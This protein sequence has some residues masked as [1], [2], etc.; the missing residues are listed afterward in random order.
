MTDIN[1]QKKVEEGEKHVLDLH[2][3]LIDTIPSPIFYK[4]ANRIYLGG[5]K[6]F[7]R[8]LGLTSEQYIGKTVF[9]ISPKELAEKYDLADRSLLDHPGVQT[10]EASVVYADGTRHDVIF[11]KSTF[12]NSEGKVAGLIGVILDIT[13]RKKAEEVLRESES[14]FRNN[15][16]NNSSVMLLID[17]LTGKITSANKAAISYFGYPE[18][19]LVGLPMNNI[20]IFSEEDSAEE[21][22]HAISDGSNTFRLKHRLASGE[23]RNVEVHL[24]PTEN[25]GRTLF[26]AIIHDVTERTQAESKLRLAATVFSHASEGI[27]ITSADAKII[28]VN[29]SFTQITGYR[30][31]EVLGC[32]PRILASGRQTKE[33]Y[34]AM[35]SDLNEKGQWRG[36]IWNRRKNGEVYAELLTVSAVRDAK[37]KTHQYVALFSDISQLKEHQHELERIAHHD[38]LTSLPNRVLLADRLHQAMAQTLRRGN[39]L[40]VGYLDLDGFKAVNDKYGHEVGDQ[41]LMATAAR[42]K[43]VLREGDTLARLGGDEFVV[44]FVDLVDSNTCETTLGRLLAA[45]AQPLHLGGLVLQLSAS[46]GV[47]YYPQSE[48]VAADLLLR[49]ADQA[50]YR[51]KAN[52]KNCYSIFEADAGK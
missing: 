50:M 21:Q 43:H 27:M 11:Y 38:A 42:M 3:P 18:E 33:F 30:R 22:E 48:D 4:D 29:D 14:N 41:L 28:D 2:Q 46:L 20:S 40:A 26:F 8:Y 9:D 10:Y 36:E 24:T 6:A 49:Q 23:V 34:I 25:S 12:E 39:R 47:T 1:A 7:D 16:E 15:F 52:G 37:N 35:W 45:V 5:N 32:N 31:E 19:K 44:V 17:P 13:E 51:A